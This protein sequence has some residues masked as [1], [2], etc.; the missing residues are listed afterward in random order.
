[1]KPLTLKLSLLFFLS[2]VLFSCSKEDDG[3]YL[4]QTVEVIN[5]NVTYSKIESNILDLVNAHRT[6]IGLSTLTKMNLV[7]GV[8]DGHTEY[9]IETGQISHDNFD[10]R[11]QELMDKAGAKSVGENVAYGYTTAESVVNGWLNSPEHKA[12]IENPNFTHFG[13]ST[14]ANS[15]G[16]NFFTQMFIKK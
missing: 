5:K 1:M 7:S 13:I 10:E 3:I 8:A 6:S 14:E 9:M 16:R 4:N 2:F 15:D 12:I 11:A